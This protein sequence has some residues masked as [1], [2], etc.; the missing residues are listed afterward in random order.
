VLFPESITTKLVAP[1]YLV[2]KSQQ[3]VA[4]YSSD[5]NKLIVWDM[6]RNQQAY[7]LSL[8]SSVKD[9]SSPENT[10]RLIVALDNKIQVFSLSE[11]AQLFETKGYNYITDGGAFH[12]G[13][14]WVYTRN[15]SLFIRTLDD[16][17]LEHILPQSKQHEYWTAYFVGEAFLIAH[18]DK[19]TDLYENFQLKGSLPKE[20]SFIDEIFQFDDVIGFSTLE[21]NFQCYSTQSLKK[22]HEIQIKDD[23]QFIR[24]G[25]CVFISKEAELEVWSLSTNKRMQKIKHGMEKVYEFSIS[26]DGNLI[27]LIGRK[28]YE[29]D[30][31]VIEIKTGKEIQPTSNNNDNVG[32]T[33]HGFFSENGKYIYQISRQGILSND[34]VTGRHLDYFQLKRGYEFTDMKTPFTRLYGTQLLCKIQDTKNF[35]PSLVLIDLATHKIEWEIP[36]TLDFY[37]IKVLHTASVIQINRTEYKN[38]ENVNHIQVFD[39]KTG[40]LIASHSEP[41][42]DIKNMSFQNKKI[43]VIRD[44]MD[45]DNGMSYHHILSIYNEKNQERYSL[46]TA[47]DYSLWSTEITNK[48]IY[49]TDNKQLYAFD[50]NNPSL[51]VSNYELNRETR[52]VKVLP[53]QLVLV[54]DAE[55]KEFD[56]SMIDLK[57][58]TEQKGFK[59]IHTD[60]L[61]T[62]LTNASLDIISIDNS[63]GKQSVH[64][65]AKAISKAHPY[66]NNYWGLQSED[67]ILIYNI[68]KEELTKTIEDY[69]FTT[70]SMDGLLAL[71]GERLLDVATGYEYIEL[72]QEKYDFSNWSN[73]SIS[74]NNSKLY[75]LN[76]NNALGIWDL[77]NGGISQASI[78][79]NADGYRAPTYDEI[80]ENYIVAIREKKGE[81]NF[82]SIEEEQLSSAFGN[83]EEVKGQE[84]TKDGSHLVLT[85]NNSVRVFDLTTASNPLNIEAMSHMVLPQNRLVYDDGEA[86][87]MHD[88]Q[89][90]GVQWEQKIE[91]EYFQT[92]FGGIIQNE[93][94]L[95]NG[96]TLYILDANSGK[97]I[98][99]QRLSASVESMLG[100]PIVLIDT[101]IYV[102]VGS[103]FNPDMKKFVWYNSKLKKSN[104]GKKDL[105]YGEEIVESFDLNENTAWAYAHD[106]V[107]RYSYPDKKVAIHQISSKKLLYEVDITIENVQILIDIRE[108]NTV[109]VKTRAGEIFFFDLRPNSPKHTAYKLKGNDFTLNNNWVYASDFGKKI[110][111]YPLFSEKPL[112]SILPMAKGD[113]FIYTPEGY[114][115]STKNGARQIQFEIDE[116]RYSFEQLDAIYNRPDLVLSQFPNANFDII[117]GYEQA[118]KKRRQRT[119]TQVVFDADQLPSISISNKSEIPKTALEPKLSLR[120]VIDGKNSNVDHVLLKVNDN[121]ERVE[122]PENSTE[123]SLSVELNNGNNAIEVSCV[124]STGMKSLSDKVSTHFQSSQ[125]GKVYFFGLGVSDYEQSDYNLKYAAKDIHDLTETLSMRYPNLIVDTLLNDSATKENIEQWKKQLQSTSVNDLVLFSFC[126]HGVLNDSM[127]WFFATHKMDFDSPETEGLSYSELL[128]LVNMANARK[129]LITLDACHSG[130]IDVDQKKLARLKKS[131]VKPYQRGVYVIESEKKSDQSFA[132]M[133]ELFSDLESTGAVVISASGGMEFALENAAYQNGIFTYS[134]IETLET[135]IWN[136]LSISELQE[137]VITKVQTRSFGLQKPTVRSGVLNYDWV[138]W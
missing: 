113:Y 9:V 118:L 19:G 53:N 46:N 116:K 62:V 4:V 58:Q 108:D 52:I 124:N 42:N 123:L 121:L 11:G 40:S 77:N 59:L 43:H 114:Y 74:S 64:N 36:M 66:N 26:Q 101:S 1:K 92:F 18:H 16:F 32:Y 89:S 96:S 38:S 65:W 88:F 35:N 78:L 119:Q 76:N 51:F 49:C 84:I 75:F 27:S 3:R 70:L 55:Q 137:Q 106:L 6:K 24:S 80:A 134:F 22:K 129:K 45:Y 21:R 50:L 128:D 107:F 29:Y 85:T 39:F 47:T 117:D 57:K 10:D 133:K 60:D 86:I 72:D 15:D 61:R 132:M 5:D 91:H 31:K 131:S 44:S 136:T 105:S 122:V 93:L 111:V 90:Q 120:V 138:I 81:F 54:K 37:N 30:V 20:F 2:N 23:E 109:F 127:D 100:N 14:H 99:T 13:N 125:S 83:L 34:V 41:G 104:F 12:S 25:N 98:T 17:K 102:N 95:I 97:T 28:D 112:Y 94:I 130:E 79:F 68:K 48:F 33:T 87:I 69:R 63:S 56:I 8:E 71:D 103:A 110:D 7:S 73:L 126:G 135:S 67:S 115:K 82:Y